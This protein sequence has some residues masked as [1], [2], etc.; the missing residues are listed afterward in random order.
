MGLSVGAQSNKSLGKTDGTVA[1]KRYFD[2]GQHRGGFVTAERVVVWDFPG[3]H[4]G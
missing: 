4:H 2:A 1:G 3:E